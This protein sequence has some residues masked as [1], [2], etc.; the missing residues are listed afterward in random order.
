MSNEL[1]RLIRD[2]VR[3]GITVFETSSDPMVTRHLSPIE[4]S[5]VAWVV[6]GLLK[7][8]TDPEILDQVALRR[9]LALPAGKVKDPDPAVQTVVNAV[10]SLLVA[11]PNEYLHT[12]LQAVALR[13]IARD[14]SMVDPLEPECIAPTLMDVLRNVEELCS[15]RHLA[16]AYGTIPDN[17]YERGAAA[18]AEEIL[19][20]I[21]GAT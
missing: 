9:L 14:T 1:R 7:R 3:R 4:C 11:V 2:E 13:F 8:I 15:R 17:D 19:H 16:V 21:R 20:L 10:D 12:A 18:L 6:S 5:H